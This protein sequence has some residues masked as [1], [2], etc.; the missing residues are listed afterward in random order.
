MRTTDGC[1]RRAKGRS[2]KTAQERPLL[3][4]WLGRMPPQSPSCSMGGAVSSTLC[5]QTIAA[6]RSRISPSR[7]QLLQIAAGLAECERRRG[8]PV[9]EVTDAGAE[10]NPG[11]ATTRSDE[12]IAENRSVRDSC[13]RGPTIGTSTEEGQELVRDRHR[14]P[15]SAPRRLQPP[16][17]HSSMPP[18]KVQWNPQCEPFSE[19]PASQRSTISTRC[20]WVPRRLNWWSAPGMTSKRIFSF[21]PGAASSRRR[22]WR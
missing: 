1:A 2:A 8:G 9:E 4:R 12:N 18:P 6:K 3:Y 5:R 19:I 11:D 22:M 21:T 13:S 10:R 20:S 15:R 7:E 17:P 16:R 14:T